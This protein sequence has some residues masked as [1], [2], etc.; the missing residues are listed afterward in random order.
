MK[1]SVHGRHRLG[2]R[3]SAA[4]RIAGIVVAGTVAVIA[5]GLSIPAAGSYALWNSA[6][7]V[8]AGSI[9]S[10]SV[11]AAVAVNPSLAVAYTSS[12]LSKTGGF[13]VTNQGT[14]SANYTTAV[15]LRSGSNSAL[16]KAIAVTAW[17]TSSVAQCSSPT[18]QVVGTWASAPVL[19]G[20]LAAGASQA[21]CVL[22][23]LGSASGIASGSAIYPT[24]SAT[25][26]VGGWSSSASATEFTQSLT[27][28]AAPSVP[29]ALVASATTTTTTRID[30]RAS[31]DNVGVKD[32]LVYR[33]STLVATITAPTTGFADSGLTSATSYSY[34]VKARDAAGNVSAASTALVVT[35]TTALSCEST[36]WMATYR[37]ATPSGDPASL[38]YAL[39]VNGV[40]LQTGADG[41]NSYVQVPGYATAYLDSLPA[42]PA[43]VEVRQVLANK[44]EISIGTGVVVLGS[45]SYRT[46]TCG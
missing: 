39:Y 27:D 26:S 21:Y 17:K 25:L 35:T 40:S 12:I 37:W 38:K 11:T 32:Y 34:T 43:T 41:W 30:W 16:A 10:G 20:T 44:T 23:T 9:Q 4:R 8:N 22:S 6:T 1:S 13:T 28:N 7:T 5:I 2:G 42:G 15:A 19:I 46:Y 33:G 18:A 24:M 45:P 29:T 31:T 14:A 36:T 3:R